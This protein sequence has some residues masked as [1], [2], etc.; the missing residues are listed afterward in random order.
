MYSTVYV[1]N[2]NVI[3]AVVINSK[4]GL[5]I[6]DATV[7]FTVKDSD[8]T[9]LTG[10]TWPTTMDYVPSSDGVYRGTLKATTNLVQADK[11]IAVI[12]ILTI[13]GPVGQKV[14]NLK[15]AINDC[16]TSPA[17]AA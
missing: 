10:Q 1:N 3:E 14:C 16:D 2:D 15:A 17:C 12:D 4:T 9:N 5:P 11:Y 13:E 7:S 8:G 6:N